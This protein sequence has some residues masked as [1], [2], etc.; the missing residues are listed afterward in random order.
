MHVLQI[1]SLDLHIAYAN[2]IGMPSQFFNFF[3]FSFCNYIIVLAYCLVWCS[4]AKIISYEWS[5]LCSSM[6]I[7][8]SQ[9][10]RNVYKPSVGSIHPFLLDEMTVSLPSCNILN[11]DNQFIGQIWHINH[12]TRSS[13][14][15]TY[16][17]WEFAICS[18]VKWSKI[19]GK[20]CL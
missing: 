17:A 10:V 2:V 6:Q 5:C 4:V 1:I 12:L 3:W 14:P 7:T 19:S 15:C 16:Q 9:T 8:V 13:S 20:C 11:T 18:V